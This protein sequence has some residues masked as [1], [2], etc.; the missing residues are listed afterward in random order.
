MKRINV[1]KLAIADSLY[2]L[3]SEVIAPGTGIHPVD[4]WKGF[5]A[6]VSELKPV[7]DA[8]L[9]KR[10]SLQA[11]IDKWHQA[12]PG[13]I[14]DA[15]AY[16]QFLSDI[17][18][19]ENEGVDFEI[20]TQ[21]TDDE[22][23]LLAGPQL[24]VPVKNARFALN[25]ANARWGSLYD[26]LYGTD[27]IALTG[28]TAPLASGY[29]PKRGDAVI[30]FGRTFLNQAV[31]LQS[32]SHTDVVAYAILDQTLHMTL[33]NGDTTGLAAPECFVG[34]QGDIGTPT[35]L[36][37]R[38]HG[39]HIELQIDPTSPI[40]QSDAAGLKDIVVEAAVST[41]MDCE[42]SVV[43][44][45]AEDKVEV[46][47]N[48]T[49]LMTGTLTDTFE[50]SGK[51]MTR[52][53]AADRCYTDVQGN[54]LVFH[55]R[56]LMF[57]RNVGHLMTTDAVLFDGHE[58]PEGMLDAMVTSFAALHDL[59]SKGPVRN[60]RT[61]SIYIVK[62]KMHG[63]AEVALANT[64]FDRVED[65]LKLPRNTVKMGIMDEERRTSVNLKACIQAAKDRVVFINTGFLDR[66]G[67]E[68]HTAMHAGAMVPKGEMKQAAWIASYEDRNVD[69]AL[70][71]GFV[72]KAQIGKGMWAMPDEMADMLVQKIGHPKSGASTAWVPSPTG[73]VLHSLH[74]HQVDVRARQ[75]TLKARQQASLTDLLTLPVMATDRV[76][77]A[78]VIQSELDNNLQGLLGYVSRWIEQ[79]IGCSKVPDIQDI[80]LMEDRATLRISSQHVANWLVHGICSREQVMATMHRMAAVVDRQNAQ[81]PDYRP[82]ASDF[83]NSTAF[84]AACALVF[85]G[86]TQPNGYTEPLLHAYRKK[87]KGLALA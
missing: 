73:A 19:L 56:S 30:A 22:V 15:A 2:G 36:L 6:I 69:I 34:F 32:G 31:P 78:D 1:G 55:G 25:A 45:D 85:E 79:G 12:H 51:A 47:R 68:I 49:G 21:D 60:S 61:G 71:T 29:N 23:A 10:D 50:K 66:T 83:D 58:V 16:Q 24:V 8:L 65:V 53:L 27:A 82:M 59:S 39:L 80:G 72:G 41:I 57:V 18:Y 5:E 40:G 86:T 77:A 35:A 44:V 7:N 42:D 11:E 87:A 9:A 84:A 20:N 13:P 76:L 63:S 43:A 48:W 70:R 75:E 3:V 37:L 17:G 33:A 54:E 28:D 67:D 26:A 64:L 81:D 52:S 38:H 62:P 74:Y 4:F 46:Y 14:A